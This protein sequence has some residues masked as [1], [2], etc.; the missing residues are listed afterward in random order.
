M[1]KL[2]SKEITLN[3]KVIFHFLIGVTGLISVLLHIFFSDK[4]FVT[5]TKF[6][7]QSNLI[8][9]ITFTFSAFSLL[10]K[11]ERN[12]ILSFCK[13]AA[14]IYMI[15]N[16]ITYHLILSSGGTY[17]GLRI[18]TNFILHYL[19]PAFVVFNW[20][21]LE[22]K[23]IYKYKMIIYWLIFPVFYCIFSLIRG[24]FDGF[25]PYF[26]LNPN[27]KIPVGVGSYENVVSFIIGFAFVFSV[28]GFGLIYLNRIILHITNKKFK[29]KNVISEG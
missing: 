23:E 6:T 11:K 7:I 29:D 16:S 13:N 4:P 17:I 28:L 5:I 18:I 27:G 24:S 22:K 25:Y 19:I 14:L 1:S 3:A 8:V 9:A 20:I 15:V 10:Y 12:N 26:F 2:H 21:S